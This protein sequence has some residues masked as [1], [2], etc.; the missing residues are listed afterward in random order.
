MAST[1]DEYR[2]VSNEIP[3]ETFTPLPALIRK[4][5]ATLGDALALRVGD[6]RL[7][8]A[9]LGDKVERCAA[10][11]REVGF[12][13]GQV[14]GIL[15]D[16]TIEYMIAYLAGLSAGG[17]VAPLPAT[18]TEETLSRMV[19][20]ADASV[21]L[22]GSTMIDRAE[23]V[24]A[25]SGL[26]GKSARLCLDAELPGWPHLMAKA[27][28][29]HTLPEPVEIQPEWLFNIIYSSGTTGVPKGIMH[30]H[31][32]RARQIPRFTMNGLAPGKSLIAA[33]T[34]YS[35]TSLVAVFGTLGNG[36]ALILQKRFDAEGFMQL[37][38]EHGITHAM[39]VPVI[40]HRLLS[41]PKFGE[42]DISTLEKSFVTSSILQVHVKEDVLK[43]W[44]GTLLEM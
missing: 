24:L 25:G 10:A 37:I 40:V 28:A 14:L 31:R 35:N 17:C 3:D 21:F 29:I 38:A 43:R 22:A 27:A 19:A 18:N 30:E 41:H 13:P 34:L 8:W 44:P 16:T 4:H 20:D 6:D 15:S 1:G 9:E 36:G 42:I 12:G 5:A 32:F 26:G 39:T 33:T 7:S 23:I 11:L 2:I